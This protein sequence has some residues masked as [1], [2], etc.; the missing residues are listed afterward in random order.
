MALAPPAFQF[1]AG[2][3]LV[4]T[5]TLSNAEVGAY[6]RLLCHQWVNGGI[7]PDLKLISKIV[8]E[9]VPRTGRLMDRIRG[10]LVLDRDGL[11]KHP[12]LEAV[13]QKQLDYNDIRTVNGSKGG[14]P[15]K[16]HTVSGHQN[17]NETS[18]I[19]DLHSSRT[20]RTR[21]AL[22]PH[23]VENSDRKTRRAPEPEPPSVKV[24]AAMILKEGILQI[25]RTAD[26]AEAAKSRA[27]RLGLSYDS[28]AIANALAS[29]QAQASKHGM[30]SS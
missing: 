22:P 13:R 24:L 18:L 28:E 17:L 12:R 23:P 9:N 29:A 19:S 27:A 10:K 15:T 6:I 2:D 25:P 5:T 8:H 21:A 30:V 7:P 4:S 26:Q 16:N 11:L 1:Y 20:E 14:R 3:F